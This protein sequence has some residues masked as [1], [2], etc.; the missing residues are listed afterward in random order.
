MPNGQDVA[1]VDF[2]AVAEAQAAKA[3]L[4]TIDPHR[5]V[6]VPAALVVRESAPLPARFTN[7]R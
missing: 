7:C 2:E 3:G 5:V 1:L 4:T 6:A